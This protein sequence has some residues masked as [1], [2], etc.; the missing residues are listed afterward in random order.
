MLAYHQ[1]ALWRLLVTESVGAPA[2]GGTPHAGPGLF[3]AL[4]SLPELRRFSAHA[5]PALHCG[6][7]TM[8]YQC[9]TCGNEMTERAAGEEE[10]SKRVKYNGCCWNKRS[11]TVQAGSERQCQ[12]ETR[13][14]RL[15]ERKQVA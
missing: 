15:R 1:E 14:R 10:P 12:I 9:T 4:A 6:K 3:K 5:Q 2:S 7:D 11:Y 13:A 8:F